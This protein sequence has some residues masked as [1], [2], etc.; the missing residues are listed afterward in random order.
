MK[1]IS[2]FI[3]FKF[4][5]PAPSSFK[6]EFLNELHTSLLPYTDFHI[7]VRSFERVIA[8]FDLD[9]SSKSLYMQLLL[10]FKWGFYF[11]LPYGDWYIATLSLLDH[12]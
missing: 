1:I 2:F 7:N 12:F 5:N 11:L 8:L 10:H 3:I 9:I 6:G 4:V